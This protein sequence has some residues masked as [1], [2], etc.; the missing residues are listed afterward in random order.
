MDVK[1]TLFDPQ[2]IQIQTEDMDYYD[3]MRD[4][5]TRYVPGFRFV[6]AYKTGRWNGKICLI[7]EFRRT[8]PY[9]I[10]MDYIRVHK[11]HFPRNPLKV[12]K[13]VL[14]LFRGPMV[15]I[16]YNLT[17]YPRPYQV[18]CIEA[19][20]KHTKGIIRSATASGKS[21][22]ITYIIKTL[23]ESKL[24]EKAIII[25]PSLSLITQ[26]RNDMVEYGFKDEHIGEVWA[27]RKQWDKSIV[28]STWQSLSRNA[29]RMSEFGAVIVDETHGAKAHELKKILGQ[30]SNAKYRLGFTG[31]MPVNALDKWN[32][33]ALLGPIIRD[34]PAGLLAEQGYISKC[35]VNMLNVNYVQEYKGEYNDVRDAVFQNKFRKQLI[36]MLAKKLDHNV[37]LLVDKVAKEGEVLEKYLKEKTN[38]TVVFIS[39]RD[40]V[41]VRE[42]WRKECIVKKDIILIATYGIFQQGI[43]IP[44]LKY[45]I[46]ASAF[47]A[48]IRVL[49]SIGRALRKHADKEEGALIYD[50]CDQTKFFDKYSKLRLR[51]Y[52]SEK[53]G[54]KEYK[55]SESSN[56]F[57]L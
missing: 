32:T 51:Y 38:K 48:K 42:K 5:F 52:D 17:L 12:D 36:G 23:L 20:L 16:N 10:L 27:E 21:L 1:L 9:G 41:A 29:E 6:P 4:E 44:N 15:E 14:D 39:G 7:Q 57:N 50:I 2:T 56:N 35:T 24:I 53:F 31:T 19:A 26:F 43:N 46:L 49:Q 34:Y 40:S 55:Y 18:D 8:F 28:I 11:E 3:M 22:V 30:A 25:V 54:I 33:K 37:L 45:I 13:E 47:K